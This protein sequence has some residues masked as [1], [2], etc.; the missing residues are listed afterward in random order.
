MFLAWHLSSVVVACTLIG[1]VFSWWVVLIKLAFENTEQAG[2][3]VVK[4]HIQ[5]EL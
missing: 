5:N 3:S 2:N 1:S 4:P